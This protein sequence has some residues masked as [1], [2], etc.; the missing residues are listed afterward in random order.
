[1]PGQTKVKS[2]AS[3][4]IGGIALEPTSEG[5]PSGKSTLFDNPLGHETGV[6]DLLVTIYPAVEWVLGSG[7]GLRAVGPK[8]WAP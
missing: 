4:L 3:D 5:T 6:L 7:R 1:V 8:R 2:K